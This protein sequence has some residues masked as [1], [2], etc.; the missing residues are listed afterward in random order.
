MIKKEDLKVGLLVWWTRNGDWSSW[1]CPCVVTYVNIE[2]NWF[3]VLSFDD[4]KETEHEL[5]IDESDKTS[6]SE[7]KIVTVDDVVEYFDDSN[8]DSKGKI[9]ELESKIKKQKKIIKINNKICDKIE[10]GELFD[11]LNNK[12]KRTIIK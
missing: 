7:M 12:D 8:K 4:M 2:E 11:Y 6:L 3:R 5:A 10:K 9:S 1:D